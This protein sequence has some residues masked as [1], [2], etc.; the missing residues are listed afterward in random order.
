MICN[1]LEYWKDEHRFSN[2]KAVAKE[3]LRITA[4]SASLERVFSHTGEY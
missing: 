4:T 3:V 2:L 1:A